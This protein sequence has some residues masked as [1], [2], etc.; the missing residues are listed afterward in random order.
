MHFALHAA[1]QEIG[2]NDS[3]K[4]FIYIYDE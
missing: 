3:A 1:S 2:H 4:N